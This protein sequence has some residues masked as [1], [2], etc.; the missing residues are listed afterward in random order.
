MNVVNLSARLAYFA[1]EPDAQ[2]FANAIEAPESRIVPS[3]AFL[4]VFKKNALQKGEGFALQYVAVVQQGR[5][6][7]LDAALVLLVTTLRAHQKMPSADG[8]IHATTQ[9]GNTLMQSKNVILK[10]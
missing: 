6:V 8:I 9:Q 5:V 2:H 10:T 1:D 3:I 4:E 7:A